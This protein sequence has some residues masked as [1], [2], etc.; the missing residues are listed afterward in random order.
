MA[1]ASVIKILLAGLLI[2]CLSGCAGHAQQAQTVTAPAGQPAPTVVAHRDYHDPLIRV[3]RAVFAFNDVVYRYATIPIAEGYQWLLPQPVRTSIGN[4]FH[5]IKMPIRSINYLAQGKAKAA[6]IDAIRFAINT[7]VGLAG[8][9]D[10]AAKWFSLER[11]DNSF[12]QTVSRYGGGY[13]FYLVLPFLGPSD[14]RNGSAVIA[15]Y[16]LNPIPYI[17]S[18]PDTSLIMTT[19]Q[20]QSFGPQ[21]SRYEKLRAESDDPYLFFRNLYLQGVQRDAAYDHTNCEA[22]AESE[23]C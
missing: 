9:F 2:A 20:L 18:Q 5:N 4:A 17:T 10:P 11:S 22:N 21:A 7:T 19:D 14:L 1:Y 6:G 23:P 3:N 12:E 16:L 8:L 15:D 13:G